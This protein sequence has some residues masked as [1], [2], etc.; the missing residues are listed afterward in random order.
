MY[1]KRL[2]ACLLGGVIAAVVCII[3]RQLFFGNP[4][5]TWDTI[6]YTMLNRVLLGFVIAVSGW[7]INRFSHGAFLG[8][9]VTLSVSLGFLISDPIRFLLYTSAGVI[10]GV[11]IEWLST[12]LF[13]APMK[14]G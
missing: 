11:F 3:G 13:K 4:S 14:A 9:I 10:Y 1:K 2:Y 5:I 8:L 6:A 12:D 7:K